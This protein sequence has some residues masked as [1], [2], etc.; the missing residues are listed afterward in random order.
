MWPSDDFGRTFEGW[1]SRRLARERASAGQAGDDV[2]RA[3][4]SGRKRRT[5]DRVQRIQRTGRSGDIRAAG[6]GASLTELADPTP[7][8][9]LKP[10]RRIRWGGGSYPLT[11]SAPQERPA[12]LLCRRC[13]S[14]VSPLPPA[15]T[16]DTTLV[17]ALFCIP[18]RRMS[19]SMKVSWTGKHSAGFSRTR[20]RLSP[21]A[22]RIV[23]KVMKFG[24]STFVTEALVLV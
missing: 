16:E 4:R 21:L 2:G 17:Q 20:L 3:A 11:R 12:K 23:G 9:D 24:I 10:T 18:S 13:D 7:K 19:R 5:G 8:R 14:L 22:S 6:R 15:S 1:L